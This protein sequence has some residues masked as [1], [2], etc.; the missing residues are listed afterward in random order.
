MAINRAS[1]QARRVERLFGTDGVRGVAN[2]ELSAL[3]A[4]KL[5]AASAYVLR[6]KHEGAKMLMGRDTRISGDI[7]ESAMASGI[8]AMGVDVYLAGVVPTPAVAF[9]ART[10]EADAGVV[11]SASHNP[12]PDNGIKFFGSDGQKLDDGITDEIERYVAEFDSLPYPEGAG[13]GRMHRIHAEFINAYLDH[14]RDVF[15]YP[16]TG[17][18]VALDCANGAVSELAPKLF[19][20]LGAETTV[21]NARPDGLNINERC[22]SLYPEALQECV[23]E[24]RIH[25]GLAFDGDGDRAI[26]VDEHGEI[27]D[28]DHIMAIC[29]LHLARHGRLAGNTVVATVMSNMGLEVALRAEGISLIRTQVGDRYVAEAMRATGAILGGEKSGHVIFGEH[30]TTG[31]GMVTGLQVLSV[32]LETGKTLSELADQMVEYPQLLVNIPVRDKSGW[33]DDPEIMSAIRSGEERLNGRGRVLV[34]ASG[35]E[36]L[37]RVM[38]EG[39]DYEELEQ[40]ATEIGNAIR[41]ALG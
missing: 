29:G 19:A 1:I 14:L 3:L 38:A 2:S 32:M 21:I 16:L 10:M 30:S 18:K 6:T 4:L 28:G 40:I 13:V 35:T 31:D 9:V 12:M 11:I 22:G 27:V 23:K 25:I 24:N 39:P 36:R 20:E 26:L 33:E 8:C 17:M 34:R 15:P 5:G 7:L 37:I 41:R